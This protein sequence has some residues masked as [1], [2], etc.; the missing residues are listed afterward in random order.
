M[1]K[2]TMLLLSSSALLFTGC[3]QS[4]SHRHANVMDEQ[5]VHRYGVNVPKKDWAAQGR[6]GKVITTLNN[7]VVVTK[8]YS[9]G[10]LDGDTTYTFPHKEKIQKVEKY[11][12]GDL[13]QEIYYD[14]TGIPIEECQHHGDGVRSVVKWNEDGVPR[15]KE[16]YQE[17]LLTEAEYYTA[18]HKVE[19]RVDN[20]FGTRLTRDEYGT[21]ISFDTIEHGKMVLSTT[22]H[23]NG[24][25]KAITPYQ[26]EIVEGYRKT[27]L[28][29]GEPDAVEE[30]RDGVQQGITTIYRNGE[31]IAEVPYENNVKHGIEKHYNDGTVVVEDVTWVNGLKHGPSN[32]YINGRVSKTDWFWNGEQISK[33]AYDLKVAPRL[34]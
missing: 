6:T 16:T 27:F 14:R 20:G 30:W 32:T 28:P 29:A 3:M 4:G 18:A 25:P 24:S 10:N 9:E 8:S 26:N 15:C 13:V 22:Y 7:G 11:V 33:S 2:L 17:D 19:S 1:R 23:P 21:V 34:H 5:Y 12:Q 31:K